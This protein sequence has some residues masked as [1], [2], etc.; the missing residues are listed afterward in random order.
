MSD[1]PY[2][3][4]DNTHVLIAGATGAGRKYGGKTVTANWWVTR[5]VE[6]GEHDVGLFWNPKGQS[7][8]RGRTVESL[9][10]LAESYR[11]G[12][13][14]FDYRPAH[15]H[16]VEEHGDVV[17][18]LRN[19]PGNKIVAHDEAQ[20]LRD[21]DSLDWCLSQGGNLRDSD[22]T[23]GDIRSLVLTQRPWNLPEELRA[24]MPLKVW[25]GPFGQEARRY[26]RDEQM[27]EAAEKIEQ[28]TGQYRWSVTD[29]GD[30]VETHAPV[31][32]EFA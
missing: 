18:F 21:A 3:L 20:D 11:A 7:F 6:S 19:V 12:Y 27:R 22:F 14:H 13:R 28:A 9:K 2:Y 5:A 30:Y 32:E 24:N 15:G 1:A 26:F 31:P 4:T 10:G 8:I 17:A 29:A 25:V 16:E 23:T